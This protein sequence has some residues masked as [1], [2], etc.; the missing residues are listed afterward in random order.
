M[1]KQKPA[2]TFRYSVTS[3]APPSDVYDV[4]AD[5]STHLAW[6]GEP[7]PKERYALLSLDAPQGR[8]TVGTKWTSTGA[9]SRDGSSTFHDRATVTEASGNVFAFE[10]DSRLTRKHRPEW[11]VLF[12]HRYAIEPEGDG[13]RINYVNDVY[14]VNYRPCWLFPLARPLTKLAV[15][16]GDMKTMENLARLA[17]QR[18]KAKR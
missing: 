7:D 9:A 15:R 10:T 3:K 2:I 8:A 13:S 5:L 6:A 1:S 14:P 12:T 4:L 11:R 17:E 18:S 16:K